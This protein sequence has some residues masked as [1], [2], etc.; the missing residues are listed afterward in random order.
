MCPEERTGENEIFEKA[1]F[2]NHS[3]TI[4]Q[5][6]ICALAK[7]IVRGCQTC[8]LRVQRNFLRV[9]GRAQKFSKFLHFEGK[10]SDLRR[11]SSGQG[12]ENLILRVHENN[13]RKKLS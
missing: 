10:L 1:E 8:I 11:N 2:L 3:R 4:D 12:F 13:L 9:S 7:N 5:K 6:N